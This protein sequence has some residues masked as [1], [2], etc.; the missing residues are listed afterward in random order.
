MHWKYV[1]M[2]D[3]ITRFSTGIVGYSETCTICYGLLHVLQHIFEGSERFPELLEDTYDFGIYQIILW[4]SESSTGWKILFDLRRPNMMR[5]AGYID[6]TGF[7]PFSSKWIKM[8]Q[9]S[10]G[11]IL[12]VFRRLNYLLSLRMGLGCSLYPEYAQKVSDIRYWHDSSDVF[13]KSSFEKLC[14]SMSGATSGLF[15]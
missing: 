4:D 15:A 11:V 8:N 7:C 5:I 2:S 1:T 12:K 3:C 6:S 14:A 10:T 9:K 13:P